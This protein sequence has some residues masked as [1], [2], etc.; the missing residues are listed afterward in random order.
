MVCAWVVY[1]LDRAGVP[2]IIT[3]PLL[4]L[5]G[6][7]PLLC[8][9]TLSAYLVQFFHREMK[10]NKTIKTGKVEVKKNTP[11]MAYNF[12]KILVTDQKAE[13]RLFYYE[14]LMLMIL[15]IFCVLHRYY[16]LS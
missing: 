3:S 11:P 15:I 16:G 1:H 5:V 14:V 7:G 9:I 12:Q 6:Y 10:W 2:Q 13:R 4:L 8:V